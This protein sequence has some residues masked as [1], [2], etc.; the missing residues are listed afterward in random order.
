MD[1]YG[2]PQNSG[3]S[4]GALWRAGAGAA[5]RKAKCF[6]LVYFWLLFFDVVFESLFLGNR[7][8][9]PRPQTRGAGAHRPRNQF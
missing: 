3:N 6:V 4:P 5:R 8:P 7:D 2:H 1:Q 9:P